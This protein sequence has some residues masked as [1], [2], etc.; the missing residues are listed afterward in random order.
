MQRLD[1][2]DVPDHELGGPCFPCRW[3]EKTGEAGAEIGYRCRQHAQRA[4]PFRKGESLN[5]VAGVL[6][7]GAIARGGNMIRVIQP[8]HARSLKVAVLGCRQPERQH[9]QGDDA[10]KGVQAD[11]AAGDVFPAC[12]N[13]LV[14]PAWQSAPAPL[15]EQAPP[16][17]L[18][19]S[20]TRVIPP[21]SLA[22]D[23]GGWKSDAGIWQDNGIQPRHALTTCQM[24]FMKTVPSSF[25]PQVCTILTATIFN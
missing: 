12:I 23:V 19:P 15:G 6:R 14:Q 4:R 8:L 10:E 24:G 18:L 21:G 7:T 13:D 25:S 2:G 1:F 9:E 17:P 20:S 22:S 11:S 3:P 16:E 5:A